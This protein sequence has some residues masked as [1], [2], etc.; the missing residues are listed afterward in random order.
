MQRVLVLLPMCVL[1]LLLAATPGC[2][3]PS[4]N[5]PETAPAISRTTS[6]G[7]ITATLTISPGDADLETD[8]L[9]SLEI[10]A[11][12][13]I[14]IMLPSLDGRLQGL[15]APNGTFDDPVVRTDG[16][17]LWRRHARLVPGLANE[18]RIAPL[19]VTFA[20]ASISPPQEGWFTTPPILLPTRPETAAPAGNVSTKLSYRWIRPPN[21]T[22]LLGATFT[23]LGAG[24]IAGLV[25]L[26]R[27]L[28]RKTTLARLTPRQRALA[29]LEKLLAANLIEKNLIKDFYVELTMVVRRYIERQHHVRAP[30]QTTEEFLQS[31]SED[32]RFSKE[33]VSRLKAFLQAADLVKFAAYT[34]GGA[35]VDHAVSTARDYVDGDAQ[36]QPDLK[37]GA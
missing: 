7:S 37:G 30:E 23:I 10:E 6:S 16:S 9:L 34:P 33:T 26:I 31:V 11:P 5:A 12:A 27:K 18:Y 2:R 28:H 20:D 17:R 21:R 22:L 36:S 1:V 3:R 32:R 19:V 4:T 25:I 29:E 35:D 14:D 15:T 8:N 24:V 13:E